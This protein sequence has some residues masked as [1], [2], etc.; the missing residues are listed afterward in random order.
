MW[1]QIIKTKVGDVRRTC[2]S[3]TDLGSMMAKT[4]LFIFI[5]KYRKSNE[6]RVYNETRKE[7]E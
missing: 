7:S 3:G 1:W 6:E 4:I 5:M 2:I